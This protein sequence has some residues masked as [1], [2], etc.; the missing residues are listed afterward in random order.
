MLNRNLPRHLEFGKDKNLFRGNNTF[1]T[2]FI[3]IHLIYFLVACNPNSAGNTTQSGSDSSTQRKTDASL[4]KKVWVAPD[5]LSIPTD[6]SGKMVHYGRELIMH[7]AK[8]LGPRGSVMQITNGMN[9][10]N[11]HLA[12]GTKPFGNN[13]SAVASTYPKFRARSGSIESIEKRIND[14][15]ERSLNG[16]KLDDNS[17]ELRAIVIYMKWLGQN[18]KRGE[19]PKGAGLYNLSYIDRA[20]DTLKGR[21]VYVQQC[22]RCHG[23]NG[24][25]KL[26]ADKIA[27][28]YP[29]L[30]GKNSYNIG[31]G[32]YR[33]SRF[34]S[35]IKANMP[36]GTNYKQP[37]LTDEEAWDVA[38]F[39]NSQ[40]RPIKNYTTDWPDKAQKPIDY[41]FGPY[42]D[43]FS[44]NEHK[45]GPF[46][47]MIAS[48]K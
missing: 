15:I 45:Y 40:Q 29:P 16:R 13:Y 12:A 7:T 33:L 34:A 2:S 10:Q 22:L 8:Y 28:E 36:Y 23:V 5:T 48:K 14:C 19:T 9:C 4:T 18:V 3:L 25:G 27:Y 39:V 20:A 46:K 31:A 24:E 32:L 6:D 44:E 30:W 47:P 21:M 37:V 42:A 17:K 35:Y 43:N 1:I 26:Y 11:C 38:A 41:P